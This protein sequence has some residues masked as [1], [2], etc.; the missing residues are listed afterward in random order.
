[1][2]DVSGREGGR[3][4]GSSPLEPNGTDE[5]D[6]TPAAA[7]P[8]EPGTSS[9][10]ACVAATRL[11]DIL[12]SLASELSERGGDDSRLIVL[13]LQALLAARE[14]LVLALEAGGEDERSKTGA[15]QDGHSTTPRALSSSDAARF[16]RAWNDSASRVIQFLK[17]RRQLQEADRGAALDR[18]LDQAL[19]ELEALPGLALVRD[20]NKPQEDSEDE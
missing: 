9:G 13:E 11:L 7:A 12:G 14:Y 20:A 16:L 17:A 1:M 6:V 5:A 8:C 4:S 2:S 18:L 19:S 15:S 10:E 3:Y